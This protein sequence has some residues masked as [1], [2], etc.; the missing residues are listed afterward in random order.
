M[1][2]PRTALKMGRMKDKRTMVAQVRVGQQS[3]LTHEP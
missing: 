2:E 1:I 3:Q